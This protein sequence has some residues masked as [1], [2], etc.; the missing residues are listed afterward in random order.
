MRKVT[1]LILAASLTVL[2]A[3]AAFADDPHRGNSGHF[4]GASCP[5]EN[6]GNPNCPSFGSK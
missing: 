1:A 6:S 3:T 4:S 2:S 5:T